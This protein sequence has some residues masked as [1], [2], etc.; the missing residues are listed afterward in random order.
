MRRITLEWVHGVAA[1]TLGLVLLG[2]SPKISFLRP[3]VDFWGNVLSIPEYPAV[4]SRDFLRN[5]YVWSRDRNDLKRQLESL[6]DE[7]AKLQIANSVLLAEQIKVELNA[8]MEDARVTLRE[9]YGWW[10]EVRIN[11]G[12]NDGIIV[13]LPVFQNGFL[14]GRVSSVSSFSSWAEL[15]T[16]SSLMIPAVIEEMRELGVVVGDGEG[17]VLLTYIPEGRGVEAGMKVSTALVSEILPPGIPV[18]TIESETAAENG[19]VT[20]KIKPG[21]SISTLYGVSILKHSRETTR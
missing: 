19:Y 6:R 21:A 14:A 9:P 16:S 17:S 3:L 15:L 4:V 7:N 20:Y 13:G 8:R 18:G 1:L 2:A 12:Q 10:N 11:K 5:L